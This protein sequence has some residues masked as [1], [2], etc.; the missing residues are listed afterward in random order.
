MPAPPDEVVQ[1][2]LVLPLQAQTLEVLPTRRSQFGAAGQ[3]VRG[4]CGT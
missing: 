1:A 3:P 2:D 4:Q